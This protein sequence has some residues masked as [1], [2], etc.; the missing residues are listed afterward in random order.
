MGQTEVV[1]VWPLSPFSHGSY[2]WHNQ[3][4]IHIDWSLQLLW[5]AALFWVKLTLCCLICCFS[6]LWDSQYCIH[7]PPNGSTSPAYYTLCIWYSVA[8]QTG[9]PSSNGGINSPSVKELRRIC[10]WSGQVTAVCMPPASS[11]F[12]TDSQFLTSGVTSVNR[13]WEAQTMC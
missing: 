13:I 9:Q 11:N 8:N 5:A 7:Q 12:G 6:P 4:H 10:A 3:L 2:N 1:C